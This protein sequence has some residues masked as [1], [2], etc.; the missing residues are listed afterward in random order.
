MSGPFHRIMQDFA[1]LFYPPYCMG[2]HGP[3]VQGETWVCTSCLLQLPRPGYHLY[4]ENPVY[5]RL[6]GRLPLTFAA[7][8]LLFVRGG[9]VQQLLHALKYHHAPD[10]ASFLGN[11]YGADLRQ[12]GWHQHIDIIVPVPLHVDR[13][14]KRGYNQSAAFADGLSRAMGIATDEHLL[15]RTKNTDTQTRKNR[16]MRWQNVEK[17]FVVLKPQDVK[18]KSVLLVDDVITTG[19]TLEA[20]GEAIMAAGARAVSV[21]G[22]AYAAG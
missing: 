21:A 9:R 18:G 11:V 22:I 15:M 6:A 20:C 17:A 5:L 12:A 8:F 14:K 1:S 2:C 19:A 4:R 10:L 7:A 13:L 3:L 16:L